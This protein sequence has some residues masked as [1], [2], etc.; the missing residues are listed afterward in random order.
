MLHQ[1]SS[2]SDDFSKIQNDSY[3][4]FLLDLDKN[5]LILTNINLSELSL[6]VAGIPCVIELSTSQ[7]LLELFIMCMSM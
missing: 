4:F 7:D 3:D 5:E 1:L 6:F 2:V